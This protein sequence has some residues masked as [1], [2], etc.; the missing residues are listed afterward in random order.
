MNNTVDLNEAIID[1]KRAIYIF[2]N[3]IKEARYLD[4]VFI[5][6]K[7]GQTLELNVTYSLTAHDKLL[8]FNVL[9]CSIIDKVDDMFHNTIVNEKCYILVCKEY[10]NSNSDNI[11]MKFNIIAMSDKLFD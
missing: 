8:K 4:N 11:R 6:D 7:D 1:K 5:E 10:T 2:T 3:I 9:K